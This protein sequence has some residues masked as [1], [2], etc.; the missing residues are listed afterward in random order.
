MQCI[1]YDAPVIPRHHVRGIRAIFIQHF[2]AAKI[3]QLQSK[4]LCHENVIWF[5][6]YNHVS[7]YLLASTALKSN[8]TSVRDPQRMNVF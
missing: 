7:T 1:R 6:V 8:F 5:D 4:V 3:Y 2:R